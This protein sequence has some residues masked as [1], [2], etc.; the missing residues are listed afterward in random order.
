M[1]EVEKLNKEIDEKEK[2][3]FNIRLL[4][5]LVGFMIFLL[6]AIFFAPE[7]LVTIRSG[8]G[9]VLYKPLAGGTDTKT[10]YGEG[11][12]LIWPWDHM[13][14]YNVRLQEKHKDIDVLTMDGL[15]IQ[16]GISMRFNP[17]TQ[18][19][20][21]L[22]KHIG[23]EYVESVVIPEVEA[24][25]RNII[26]KFD[27]EDLYSINR[28]LIQKQISDSSLKAIN[29]QIIVKTQL[30]GQPLQYV[31]FDD[32]L[33]ES[34]KL[35]EYV[36]KAIERKLEAEQES[37]EYQYRIQVAEKEARRKRI[38]AQGIVDFQ[39]ISGVS[40]LKWRGLDV[41]EAFAN[42]QNSKIV[43]MGT[44]ESLPIILNGEVPAPLDSL[45]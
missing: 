20:G 7:Y 36:S 40:I 45:R 16:V 35:P 42:S 38:E 17:N 19:L 43:I 33:I 23:P 8:E 41:T 5:F 37:D 18:T 2:P 29:Q 31:I 27:P 15:A 24:K 14:I 4:N 39:D 9:G 21:V 6:L 22:H 11:V 28:E 10:Y 13:Y 44:D 32:L 3:R 30:E 12:H 34:I 25:T 26:G 1:K